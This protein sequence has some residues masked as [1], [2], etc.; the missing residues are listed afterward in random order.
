MGWLRRLFSR[1]W[2]QNQ[3]QGTGE[4]TRD[5]FTWELTDALAHPRD[6]RRLDA[7]E[8]ATERPVT[9]VHEPEPWPKFA[10]KENRPSVLE[11][12]KN[13]LKRALKEVSRFKKTLR[14]SGFRGINTAREVRAYPAPEFQRCLGT[15]N[16]KL[17]WEDFLRE[18]RLAGNPG[19]VEAVESLIER[20]QGVTAAQIEE[21][22]L[23]LL[24]V[25]I[26]L[27]LSLINYV[28]DGSVSQ[29]G[30]QH[31]KESVQ[32]IGW[33]MA[34]AAAAVSASTAAGGSDLT[35]RIIL[36]GLSGSIAATVM[37]AIQ[38][39][40]GQRQKDRASAAILLGE[41]HDDII[42][43]VDI[44]V[45]FISEQD[46]RLKESVDGNELLRFALLKG[47]F[48]VMYARQLWAGREQFSHRTE[49]Q[50]C[51]TTLAK[52]LNA[53]DQCIQSRAYQELP[54]IKT[55]IS[56]VLFILKIY[57]P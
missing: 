14:H 32:K 31:L 20:I 44:L 25:S 38:G 52:S 6:R 34:A 53:L 41:L 9:G 56:A 50:S 46:K 55:D 24:E 2:H 19:A 51:L 47:R 45:A 33:Q 57:K 29:D 48:S 42:A 35:P 7:G 21:D 39:L 30:V 5:R 3:R 36:A 28:D 37:G 22:S 23:T 13:I 11:I 10:G 16:D 26:K 4:T 8:T 40:H 18:E 15:L 27:L 54:E 1:H 17:L 49:Y 12:A 43:Q